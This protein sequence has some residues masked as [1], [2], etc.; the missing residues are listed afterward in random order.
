MTASVEGVTPRNVWTLLKSLF[1]PGRRLA[2]FVSS[3]LLSDVGVLSGSVT[4]TGPFRFR[5]IDG[6][7]QQE[8]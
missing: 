8:R 6:Y 5:E 2:T 4:L 3:L 1:I 7:Q